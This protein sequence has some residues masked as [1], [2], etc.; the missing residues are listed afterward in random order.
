LA[1]DEVCKGGGDRLMFW[2][3]MVETIF[4]Q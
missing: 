3:G 1:F 4:S 2:V